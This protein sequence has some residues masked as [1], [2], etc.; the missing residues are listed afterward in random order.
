[1][2]GTILTQAGAR[3]YGGGAKQSTLPCLSWETQVKR[4]V[5][6][7]GR[8]CGLLLRKGRRVQ[9]ARTCATGIKVSLYICRIGAC[10]SSPPSVSH[11]VLA[12]KRGRDAGQEPP[13]T[14]RGAG[15]IGRER[16]PAKGR[17]H[18]SL[19]PSP[20][21]P[22][23]NTV[24]SRRFQPTETQPP[25]ASTPNGVDGI[26]PGGANRATVN[27]SRGWNDRAWTP[28][29]GCTYGYSWFAPCRAHWA[30]SLAVCHPRLRRALKD[31]ARPAG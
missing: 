1:M 8:L 16:H 21:C 25:P 26:G 17:S 7:Y 13:S 30:N 6:R 27:P 4:G 24:S 19:L 9:K 12:T 5:S 22:E 15:T 2:P 10:P 14:P 29:V 11:G 23:G 31:V 18:Y 28:S 20:G 3:C